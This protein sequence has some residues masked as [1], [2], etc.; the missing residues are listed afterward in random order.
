MLHDNF[1]PSLFIVFTLTHP[2]KLH[3]MEIS[4]LQTHVLISGCTL[5]LYILSLEAGKKKLCDLELRD[6]YLLYHNSTRF[7]FGVA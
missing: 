3:Q 2:D 4:K 5:P 7:F 6:L 1:C